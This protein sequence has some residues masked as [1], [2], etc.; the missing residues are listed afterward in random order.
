VVVVAVVV[1]CGWPTSSPATHIHSRERKMDCEGLENKKNK[2]K[3]CT[4]SVEERKTERLV[5]VDAS[6]RE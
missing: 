5:V 1:L 4:R 2:K 3:N 6:A